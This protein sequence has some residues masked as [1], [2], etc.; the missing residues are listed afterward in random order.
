MG[1]T[2]YNT[3]ASSFQLGKRKYGFPDFSE[4]PAGAR[5]AAVPLGAASPYTISFARVD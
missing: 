4:P 3:Y 1:R 2:R 5:R